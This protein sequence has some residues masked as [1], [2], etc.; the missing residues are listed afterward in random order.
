MVKW[1]DKLTLNEPVPYF[2]EARKE[3]GAC[4]NRFRLLTSL[5]INTPVISRTEV[6]LYQKSIAAQV[7][8]IL[9]R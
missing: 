4:I 5:S 2:L 1:R 3:E 7:S 6:S 8:E 9:S